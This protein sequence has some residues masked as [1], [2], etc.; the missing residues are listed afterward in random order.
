MNYW[1]FTVTIH[2]DIEGTYSAEDIFAQRMGDQFWGL[3]EKTPN[4]KN[5]REGDR[6]V[7]YIGQPLKVFGGSATLASPS[8]ELSETQ[9]R[10]YGHGRQFYTTELGVLLKDIDIWTTPRQVEDLILKLTFIEN[11][12]FWYS[13]FQGGVRQ[14]TEEDYLIIT[15]Q[16]DVS[17][18][19]QIATSMDLESQSEFALESHLEE[20]ISQNWDYIDW[21]S[22]LDLY[23]T[24]EQ[25]GRQFP[26][27]T[28]SIDFLAVDKKSNDLVVVELKRGKTSD[29]TVGQ[30]LRYINWVKEN[31]AESSQKVRGV[32]IAKEVD[33]ALRYAV[34]SL[35]NVDVKTY[36]VDFKLQS[37]I[38]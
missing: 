35:D 21:G 25:D 1:I 29:A 15:G 13:Y 3:G 10:Q 17:L 6:V 18:V 28:W 36:V 32:I 9:Q 34:K 22:N 38:K 4:R 8:L 7:F 5:L 23:K 11:K 19:E 24:D 27:G 12:E 37:F 14:V 26:A 2:R 31:I 20:F 16:R 33:V 30:I